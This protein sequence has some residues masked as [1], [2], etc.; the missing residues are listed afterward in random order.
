MAYRFWLLALVLALPLVGFVVSESVQSDLDSDL[1]SA[2]RE[3]YPNAEV[4]SIQ[5]LTLGSL[6]EDPDVDLPETCMHVAILSLMSGAA[7]VAGFSGLA[8][9]AVI[10]LAGVLARGSRELLLATFRPGL[11]ITSIVLVALVIAHALLAIGSLYYLGF[12][13]GLLPTGIIFALGIGALAGVLVLTRNI[14]ALVEKAQTIVIGLPV[15]PSQAPG[16]HAKIANLAKRVGALPPNHVVVGLDPNYFVT[17]AT[18]QCLAG[19]LDGRTLYCS[20]PLNRIMFRSRI[21]CH[22]LPR[23]RTL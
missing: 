16:L 22:H 13:I 10:K 14:F 12:L 19:K 2:L 23:T 5:A 18:V 21:R 9:L 11:Y 7:L 20:L 1:H 15:T 17:E 8:L 3:Q 6:C 4:D